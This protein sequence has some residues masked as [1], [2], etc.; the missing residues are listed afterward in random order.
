MDAAPLE[1]PQQALVETARVTVTELDG[2]Q[3][4]GDILD[5]LAVQLDRKTLVENALLQRVI[6]GVREDV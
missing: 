4:I 6:V 2:E 5:H 3:G 1:L